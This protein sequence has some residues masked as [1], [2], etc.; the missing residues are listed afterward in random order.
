MRKPS[1]KEL[2]DL[3][4]HVDNEGFGYYMLQY[5]PDLALIERMGFDRKQV[6]AAIKL[7]SAIED[8]IMEGEQYVDEEES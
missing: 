6:E 2:A 1:K 8:K 5:G 4:C 3:W 7:F